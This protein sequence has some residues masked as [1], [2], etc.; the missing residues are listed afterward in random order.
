MAGALR[1]ITAMH[2]CFNARSNVARFYQS[3]KQ[4]GRG[5]IGI[6]DS[7][8]ERKSLHAYLR[9]SD[10]R[11]LMAALS[12]RVIRNIDEILQRVKIED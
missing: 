1:K 9:Y 7:V 6:Q 10:E 4:V 2:G 3:R 11:M 8:T 5:L 12:T